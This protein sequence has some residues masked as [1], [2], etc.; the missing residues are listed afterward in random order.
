MLAT[1]PSAEQSMKPYIWRCH[2]LFTDRSRAIRVESCPK[3][4]N[5]IK[6]KEG[7]VRIFVDKKKFI[8]D[9]VANR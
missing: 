6:N 1:E 7:R 8:V 4:L 5:H 2:N 9:E 3:L